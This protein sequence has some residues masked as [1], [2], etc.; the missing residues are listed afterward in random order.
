ML[1]YKRMKI[2]QGRKIAKITTSQGMLLHELWKRYGGLRGA[3]TFIGIPEYLMPLWR[4]RGKV[5]LKQC[6]TVA[7]ACNIPVYALNYAEISELMGE[8]AGGWE[9]S[10]KSCGFG[11]IVENRILKLKWPSVKGK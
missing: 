3:A 9:H 1:L 11:E 6:R 5:A 4:R 10:V 7:D 8:P 2:K